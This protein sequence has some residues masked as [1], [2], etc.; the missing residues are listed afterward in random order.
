MAPADLKG[1]AIRAAGTY[2][3]R[4]VEAW[5]GAPAQISLAGLTTAL[6]RNTVDTAYTG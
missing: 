4:A 3:S 1:L 2:I 6:E 5:D